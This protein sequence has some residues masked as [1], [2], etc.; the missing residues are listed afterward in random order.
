MRRLLMVRSTRITPNL[1]TEDSRLR[2][3]CNHANESRDRMNEWKS[4]LAAAHTATLGLL[5]T[6]CFALLAPVA[7]GTAGH[8]AR[9]ISLN[10]TAHLRLVHFSGNTLVEEGK[11]AGTLPGT[12]RAKLIVGTSTVSVSFTIYLRNGAIP[13]QAAA[14]LNP[15]K[16]EYA[17][18]AGSL[19]V[20][21]GSGHYARVS[22]SGRVSG[23]ISR[24]EDL[25]V[26]QV[27]GQIRT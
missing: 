19:T 3:L 4:P 6:I 10:D 7:T 23:T 21:H 8:T 9:A 14:K 20:H 12:V 18:F 27:V 1:E 22:G 2:A 11:A 15:G 17:S 5:T 16:G 26:V 25:A 24:N 13:G